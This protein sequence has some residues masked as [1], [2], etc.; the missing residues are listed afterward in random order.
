MVPDCLSFIFQFK[1]IFAYESYKFNS[2]STK[3][4]IIDCGSNVGLSCLYFYNIFPRSHILAFEADP[5][6]FKYLIEN[7]KRSNI[8]ESVE[9]L[10]K[11]VWINEDGIELTQEGADG[12]SI[13]TSGTKIKVDSVRLKNIISNQE[14]IDLLK[15]D[16]EGAESEVIKDCDEN[17]KN[18]ERIF[19]EYHSFAGR[20][21]DLNEILEVLTKNGFR[22][23]IN[24][25]YNRE[26]P[27]INKINENNPEMD[28]QLNI[29]AYK[30]D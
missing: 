8:Y 14:R 19:V 13:Y 20:K 22:Y 10:N 15:I 5:Q 27:F 7:L 6:I 4:V 23:S 21:Q 1:E 30:N 29:F 11:A 26:Q 17:F 18:V 9:A 12:S 3:P 28:L 25:I 2:D 24:S 16:I